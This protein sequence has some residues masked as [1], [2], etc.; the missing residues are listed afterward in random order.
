MRT[1]FQCKGVDTIGVLD[2]SSPESLKIL[3]LP[4]DTHRSRAYIVPYAPAHTQAIMAFLS[5]PDAQL[6][7]SERR[8]MFKVSTQ[9]TA[10]NVRKQASAVTEPRLEW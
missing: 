7:A 8:L 9:G 1:R 10:E 5:T 6:L 2:L 3:Q 4:L